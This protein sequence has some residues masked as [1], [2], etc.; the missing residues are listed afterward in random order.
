MLNAVGLEHVFSEKVSGV[1]AKRREVERLLD[2]LKAYDVLVVTKFDPVSA[3]KARTA[4]ASSSR[5]ARRWGRA[6]LR[7]NALS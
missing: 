4:R 2:E 6:P 5:S 3:L 7:E 1:T